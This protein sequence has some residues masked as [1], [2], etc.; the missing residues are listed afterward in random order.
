MII[1]WGGGPKSEALAAHM[2]PVAV[3]MLTTLARTS[4]PAA[5]NEGMEAAVS[6]TRFDGW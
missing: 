2:L 1:G 4:M 5:R 3:R 6:T